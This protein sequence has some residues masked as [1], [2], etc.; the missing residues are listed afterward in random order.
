VATNTTRTVWPAHG[1]SDTENDAQLAR[2]VFAAPDSDL[3]S[4]RAPPLSST[5][6]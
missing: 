4:V 5:K 3:T 1:A 6:A 2:S